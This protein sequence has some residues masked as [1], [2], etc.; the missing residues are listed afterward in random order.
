[1][2]LIEAMKVAMKEM[3]WSDELIAK[4]EAYATSKFPHPDLKK[5]IDADKERQVI[6]LLKQGYVEQL[7]IKQLPGG[8]KALR[9][10][11]KAAERKLRLKSRNN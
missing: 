1:M 4:R 6:D 2:N 7:I 5:P 9:N 10:K 8:R 3:G 11:R